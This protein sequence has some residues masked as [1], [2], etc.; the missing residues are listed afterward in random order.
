ARRAADDRVASVLLP[1][2]A[3]ALATLLVLQDRGQWRFAIQMTSVVAGLGI[4]AAVAAA[5]WGL[6]RVRAPRGTLA[7]ALL[8]LLVGGVLAFRVLAPD[9]TGR[10]LSDLERFRPSSGSTGF[11]VSEVRPLLLMTGTMSL[12]VPF[13][14]FGPSFYIAL[15]A[16]L[17]LAW[18]AVRT[19]SAALGCGCASAPAWSWRPS[20][21]RRAR[22]W[23]GR[24]RATTSA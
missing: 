2:L 3:V 6:G 24:W 21:S 11:T 19:A 8:V 14:V 9:L 1:A 17:W 10:I 16:L 15:A 20:C 7:A 23:H 5:R 4:V 13:A 18:R 22:C 12:M